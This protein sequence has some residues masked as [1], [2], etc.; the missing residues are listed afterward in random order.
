MEKWTNRTYST[1]PFCPKYFPKMGLKN[2]SNRD[3][4][5]TTNHFIS[6]LLTAL[7]VFGDEVRFWLKTIFLL[8][9]LS[10]QQHEKYFTCFT[11]PSGFIIHSRPDERWHSLALVGMHLAISSCTLPFIILYNAKQF[12]SSLS[13]VS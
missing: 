10:E 9:S 4:L 3:E 5:N 2:K 13:H 6:Y 1:G 8:H 12:S 7:E 11:V